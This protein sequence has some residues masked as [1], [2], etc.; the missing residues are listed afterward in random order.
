VLLVTHDM[1]ESVLLCDRILVMAA[2]PGRVVEVVD[3]AGL[4]PR[5]RGDRVDM[6][7]GMP[8]YAKLVNRIW[9]DLAEASGRR[10]GAA[11]GRE[12][13]EGS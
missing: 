13:E 4:I 5:P 11:G 10:P 7:K 6:I 12:Q 1:D 2:H 8:E 3:T 9:A